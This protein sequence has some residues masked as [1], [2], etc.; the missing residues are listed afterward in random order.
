MGRRTTDG[1]QYQGPTL[2]VEFQRDGPSV[3]VSARCEDCNFTMTLPL[4]AATVFSA[5]SAQAVDE[6][7]TGKTARFV[8]QNS[9]LE[10]HK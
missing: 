3:V 4:T 7:N 10:V 9:I 1:P 5:A 6:N 2:E 8:L